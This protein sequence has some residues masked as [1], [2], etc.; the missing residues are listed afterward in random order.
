MIKLIRN[1]FRKK[2]NLIP[3]LEFLQDKDNI[4]DCDADIHAINA[5]FTCFVD[6]EHSSFFNL[7]NVGS[8]PEM[9]ALYFGSSDEGQVT[10]PGVQTKNLYHLVE[11]ITVNNLWPDPNA[12]PKPEAADG[13][14]DDDSSDTFKR[15]I[16]ALDASESKHEDIGKA[17]RTYK[18]IFLY[19]AYIQVRE[20]GIHNIIGKQPFIAGC[21]AMQR[22]HNV[23]RKPKRRWLTFKKIFAIFMLC[24]IGF[25]LLY[26]L[27]AL[28]NFKL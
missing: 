4:K 21:M 7:R 24:A 6:Y 13:Y 5:F 12:E 17:F 9:A 8:S 10:F 18:L 28:S 25:V 11:F 23:T 22:V 27:N 26:Y 1:I 15:V 19:I 16:E 14:S 2:T 3:T 20:V